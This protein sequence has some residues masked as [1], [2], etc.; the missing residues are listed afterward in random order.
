MG[1][2]IDDIKEQY[3]MRDV[4][5]RYGFQVDR[6]GFINCPFHAGDNT[7]SLKLYK[8]N[9]YCFGCH[10]HGDIFTFIQKMDDCDFKTAF[11][12]LGG[13]SGK[14]SDAAIMRLRK[15]KKE[16]ER[17][18]QRLSDA[19]R[20]LKLASSE[21]RYWMTVERD[22]EPFSTV[23]CDIQNILPKVRFFADEALIHYMN[24][25]DEGR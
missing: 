22:T 5:E 23:W 12:S 2:T 17:Y 1:M 13:E 9:F 20:G 16:K 14:L 11:K 10:E 4:V 3:S 8:D 18:R 21:L 15:R 25:I 19:L 7:A 6:G 24:V